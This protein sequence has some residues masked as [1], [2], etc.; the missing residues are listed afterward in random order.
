MTGETDSKNGSGAWKT[1]L[2]KHWNMIALFV[3]AII[4]ASIGAV[5]VF[6]WFVAQA[7][8]TGMVPSILGFWTMGNL[9][10]FILY[11]VLWELL[12]IG[13]PAIVG[14]VLGWLWWRRLPGEE[15]KEYRFFGKR[16]RTTSGGGGVSLLFFIA[17]C[18]KVFIDGKWNVP[19]FT[20]T[21]DYVVYSMVWILIW[22]LVILGIPAAIGIIWWIHHEMKKTP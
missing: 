8:S 2:R 14:V 21:F 15:R 22:I 13:V 10:T 3:A 12:L 9:V 5:Y 11:T 4:L 17:F 1:F 20:W 6:L 16:S 19:F 18:I 7:Q